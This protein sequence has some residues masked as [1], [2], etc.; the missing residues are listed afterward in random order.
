MFFLPFAR[1]LSPLLFSCADSV[2]SNMY[3][4]FLLHDKLKKK[5]EHVCRG[6]GIVQ[7]LQVTDSCLWNIPVTNMG[8]A[9]L[10]HRGVTG[11][12]LNHLLERERG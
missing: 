8:T 5:N 4:K 3:D 6:C 12:S 7:A 10:L 11:E 9:G 1:V 2:Q